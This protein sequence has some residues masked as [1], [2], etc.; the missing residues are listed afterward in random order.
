MP[1]INITVAHK[2]ANQRIEDLERLSNH[3]VSQI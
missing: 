2:V 3:R 1:D